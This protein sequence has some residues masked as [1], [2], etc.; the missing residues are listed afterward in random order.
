[1][2]C[3]HNDV[4]LDMQNLDYDRIRGAPTVPT[5]MFTEDALWKSVRYKNN[6]NPMWFRGKAV[7]ADR[8]LCHDEQDQLR[9]RMKVG[10][11]PQQQDTCMM[12][13]D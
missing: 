11:T 4:K 9:R 13:P 5:Y 10:C 1:M 7:S 2:Y 8:Y 12:I 3:G 6:R